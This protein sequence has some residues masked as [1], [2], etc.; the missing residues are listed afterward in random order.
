MPENTLDS[1]ECRSK[2]MKPSKKM[3]I[4]Y[5]PNTISQPN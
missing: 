2:Y 5:F 3:K 1:L 4:V